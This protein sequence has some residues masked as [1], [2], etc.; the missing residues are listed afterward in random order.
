MRQ[1]MQQRFATLDDT[2]NKVM[3]TLTS[4][5]ILLDQMNTLDTEIRA[6]RVT[7]EERLRRTWRQMI[8][9]AFWQQVEVS[10]E[11]QGLL[12]PLDCFCF[13]TILRA[14]LLA[15]LFCKPSMCE[16][17]Y[18]GSWC[19]LSTPFRDIQLKSLSPLLLPAK[20]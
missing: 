15:T 10:L 16:C 8:V 7:V 1:E 9:A 17:K 14:L 18:S 19:A 2:R 20:V 11:L 6:W 5:L 3:E 12:Q 4:H 13:F